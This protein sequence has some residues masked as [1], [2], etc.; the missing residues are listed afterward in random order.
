MSFADLDLFRFTRSR[1][2]G[3][4]PP[5]HGGF[6]GRGL[7]ESCDG[8]P[9]RDWLWGKWAG[10]GHNDQLRFSYPLH[11]LGLLFRRWLRLQQHHHGCIYGSK[12]WQSR[13]SA[14]LGANGFWCRSTERPRAAQRRWR[15]VLS[16]K[17][18]EM[19]F[20]GRSGRRSWAIELLDEG[21]AFSAADFKTEVAILLSAV[22]IIIIAW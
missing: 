13:R 21:A 11:N 12:I 9:S 4:S 2:H 14:S 10:N 18:L 20:S 17:F 15:Q 3:R 1:D 19:E 22:V 5:A 16:G 7:P 6:G 8:S